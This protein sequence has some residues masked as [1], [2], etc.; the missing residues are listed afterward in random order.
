MYIK[1]QFC[2]PLFWCQIWKHKERKEPGQGFIDS[3]VEFDSVDWM[4]ILNGQTGYV[5]SRACSWWWLCHKL[6]RGNLQ[7]RQQQLD[8]NGIGGQTLASLFS[9]LRT[10]D[11]TGGKRLKKWDSQQVSH[12]MRPKRAPH[13]SR[14]FTTEL[15]G[16]GQ[17]KSKKAWL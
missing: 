7:S 1:N 13:T 17:C 8:G 11:Q 15:I 2:S 16:V 5:Q 14:A 4:T 12:P 9:S 10:E 6:S 3:Q